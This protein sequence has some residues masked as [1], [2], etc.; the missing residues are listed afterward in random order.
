MKTTNCL[1]RET[2]QRYLNGAI[3]EDESGDIEAHLSVCTACEQSVWQL[4]SDPDTLLEAMRE[5]AALESQEKS[6]T[7]ES[8]I[9][10]QRAIAAARVLPNPPTSLVAPL[11]KPAQIGAYELLHSL[12]RGGMG[13]VFLA[14][15]PVSTSK[16]LSS[17]SS[18][19]PATQAWT[20]KISS[21]VFSARCGPPVDSIIPRSSPPLTQV[22]RT[23]L[24]TW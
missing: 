2:L 12:G 17:Y 13:Q 5:L 9:V 24:T 11:G 21:R 19:V 14:A 1:P 6:T 3:A 10:I 16:L 15:T 8:P 22:K 7:A 18:L 4:E 20:Q 23:V